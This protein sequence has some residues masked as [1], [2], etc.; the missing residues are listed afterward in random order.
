MTYYSGQQVEVM[1]NA[2]WQWGLYSAPVADGH[3]VRMLCNGFW[4]DGIYGDD[5]VSAEPMRF[6]R[7][8]DREDGSVE[9]VAV[10]SPFWF[11]SVERIASATGLSNIVVIDKLM[12][13]ERLRTLYAD[14]VAVIN[15]QVQLI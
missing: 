13:G 1:T 10:G 9:H 11:G 7:R 4:R 15:E 3:C 14:Y 6:L 12:A 8:I 2:G 5:H